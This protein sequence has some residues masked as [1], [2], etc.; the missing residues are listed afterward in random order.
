MD[1]FVKGIDIYN[2][3]HCLEERIDDYKVSIELLRRNI[4][5]KEPYKLLKMELDRL[6]EIKEQLDVR[7]YDTALTA[8]LL[9]GVGEP[10]SATII[11]REIRHLNKEFQDV[12]DL[13]AEVHRRSGN[14]SVAYKAVE[15]AVEQLQI[16]KDKAEQQKYVRINGV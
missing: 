7:A 8:P 14:E 11:Y 16:K 4:G 5:H 6:W 13:R 10:V 15:K 9:V 1:F 2:E 12:L 3:V